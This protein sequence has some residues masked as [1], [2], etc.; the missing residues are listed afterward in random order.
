MSHSNHLNF[1]PN[2]DLSKKFTEG[3]ATASVLMVSCKEMYAD[4]K[5]VCIRIH[6]LIS[7]IFVRRQGPTTDQ[8]L[9]RSITHSRIRGVL[10]IFC[11]FVMGIRLSRR[12]RGICKR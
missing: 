1:G 3:C 6:N 2:R 8:D 11:N 4:L 5:Q 7:S 9:H 12:R 10:L